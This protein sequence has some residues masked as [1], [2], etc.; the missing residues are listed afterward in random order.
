MKRCR[1]CG[2]TKPFEAFYRASGMKDGHRGECKPCFQAERRRKYDSADAVARVKRWR[3][4]NRERYDSYRAEYRN[5]PERKRAM[6][7]LYYRRTFGITADD[8]D[9]LLE[10]QDGKCAICGGEPA[11][12]NG[13]HVDHDHNTGRI[14]GVL[15]QRCNHAIGL[16]DEDPERLRAAADYLESA[17]R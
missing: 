7:D 5:R 15:C 8:V 13:W 16:L 10:K 12:E 4:N 14:R 2:E 3:D 9:A 11:R 17:S 1:I 6:R